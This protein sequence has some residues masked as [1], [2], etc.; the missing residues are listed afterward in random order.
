MV[1]LVEEREEEIKS[2]HSDLQQ[3]DGD[4]AGLRSEL[5]AEQQKLKEKEQERRDLEETVDVLRKELD[6]TQ[7]ARKDASIKATALEQQKSQLE[8][9]LKQKED[10]LNKHSAMIAMIHSLSSGK[11]KNDSNVSL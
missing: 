6:K 4:I 11:M 2:L 10:E 1:V 8:L 7:Q 3:K 9:K 5:R